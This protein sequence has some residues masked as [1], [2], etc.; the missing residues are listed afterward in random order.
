MKNSTPD[1]FGQALNDV[2]WNFFELIAEAEG[3][4]NAASWSKRSV[5]ICPDNHMYYDTY[6]NLLYKLGRKEEALI[7]EDKALKLARQAKSDTAT[8]EETIN[9]MNSG[10]KTWK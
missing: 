10:E 5:D 8:Y 9:K 6:A 2:A 1:K 3:L 4:E 7:I